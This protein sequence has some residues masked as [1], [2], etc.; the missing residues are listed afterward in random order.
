MVYTA[1]F[2]YLFCQFWEDGGH[3]SVSEA[4]WWNATG[5]VIIDKAMEKKKLGQKWTRFD[6][7]RAM[8]TNQTNKGPFR[9]GTT[10]PGI[11]A[12]HWPSRRCVVARE[13]QQTSLLIAPWVSFYTCYCSVFS[14]HQP[15][16]TIV[17]VVCYSSSTTSPFCCC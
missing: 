13:C 14:S 12:P 1:Q 16:T 2:L 3:S 4:P 5:D 9:A 15:P 8:Q 11:L 17:V 10:R 6:T 7:H